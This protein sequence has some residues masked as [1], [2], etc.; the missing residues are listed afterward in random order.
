M[1]APHVAG[2]AAL[3]FGYGEATNK[4]FTLAQVKNFILEGADKLTNLRGRLR[5]GD[6]E[7]PSDPSTSRNGGRLNVAIALTLAGANTGYPLPTPTPGPTPDPNATPTPIPTATPIPSAPPLA[8]GNIVYNENNIGFFP[9]ILL[10]GPDGGAGTNVASGG[11]ERREIQNPYISLKTGHIAY[12]VNLANV[13]GENFDI[14][15]FFGETVLFSFPENEIF[16]R[17]P[18]GATVRVTNDEA[19]TINPVDDREPALSPDGTRIAWVRRDA[20]GN[21]DIYI[22]DRLQDP[23]R[24]GSAPAMFKLVGDFGSTVSEERRP[25]WTPDGSRIVFNSNRPLTA[26][27]R[28]KDHDIYIVDVPASAST[29]PANGAAPSSIVRLTTAEG[30]DIEPT[31]GPTTDITRAARPRGQLAY[32]SNRDD[33]NN[34]EP[35]YEDLSR[36]IT[37][38]DY[39]I[40]IQD[41]SVENNTTNRATR[42]VDTERELNEVPGARFGP[43]SGD[44]PF[45][46]IDPNDPASADDDYY[47]SFEV[48]GDDRR[49]S[50]TADG[51]SVVFCS[52]SNFRTIYPGQNTGGVRDDNPNSDFDIIRVDVN[53]RGYRR[54]TDDTPTRTVVAVTNGVDFGQISNVSEDI[55]PIAGALVTTTTP[56]LTP[57]EAAASFRDAISGGSNVR[58]PSTNRRSRPRVVRPRQL[59]SR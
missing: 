25:Y 29:L 58:R 54:L 39:D 15:D 56:R 10:M 22:A 53:S 12:V 24:P 23:T 34:F 4:D 50:F 44:T 32:A 20:N 52:D 8:P 30:D 28:V 5:T 27:A 38:E 14:V 42:I 9:E 17:L 40:Y 37:L 43:G 11:S 31:V 26:G 51:N 55:E 21:D 47:V 59:R 16:V 13:T 36:G 57:T 33:R 35:R 49:P 6:R 41:L 1:A 7:D 3:L 45:H 46:R 48:Q 18:N 2:A 19:N